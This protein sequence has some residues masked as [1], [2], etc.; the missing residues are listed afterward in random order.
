MRLLRDLIYLKF[1]LRLPWYMVV[2]F[3][4][5]IRFHHEQYENSS[6]NGGP[7]RAH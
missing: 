6:R 4:I 1:L 3:L 7:H 5:R 2:V